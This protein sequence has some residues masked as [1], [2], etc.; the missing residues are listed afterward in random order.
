MKVTVSDVVTHVKARGVDGKAISAN[1]PIKVLRVVD[2]NVVEVDKLE[3]ETK[4]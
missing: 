2:Q 4:E 1:T 3:T